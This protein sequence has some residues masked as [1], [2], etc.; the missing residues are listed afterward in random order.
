MMKVVINKCFGGFGLSEEAWKIL[1]EK[2]GFLP[3]TYDQMEEAEY[4]DCPITWVHDSSLETK[5]EYTRYSSIMPR[6][7]HS[8]DDGC[9]FRAH[10]GVIEVVELLGEKANGNHAS[11]K[12]VEIPDGIE[13]EIGEYDGTEW[14]DEVHRSWG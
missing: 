8:N 10:P 1:I 3:K 12:V 6:F 11:L 5:E 14:I 7:Y 13:W 9:E 4:K 2:H